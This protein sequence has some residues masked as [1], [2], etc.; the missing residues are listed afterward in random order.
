MYG[1]VDLSEEEYKQ[2]YLKYKQKYNDLKQYGGI[3]NPTGVVCF[4]TSMEKANEIT[5]LFSSSS[6]KPNF[7]TISEK[8]H[9]DG[10]HLLAGGNSLELMVKP[11][12]V[13]SFFSKQ[14]ES[15]T[16]V[17]KQSKVKLARTKIFNYCDSTHIQDVKNV[18]GTYGF[19]PE[20]MF[21]VLLNN[22]GADALITEKPVQIAEKPVQ[23][24]EKPVQVAENIVQNTEK[25]VQ[26]NE[27][28][29]QNTEKPVQN[30]EN[31][32]QNT[33][34][35]VQNAA[36]SEQNATRSEQNY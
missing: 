9:N 18:L 22:V 29:V 11:K 13:A 4:F 15:Q 33:E 36:R 30:A 21:V 17:L 26:N 1:V 12:K 27:K 5:A 2:K 3:G 14:T 25:P 20:A 7:N 16:E 19:V 28:L 23:V 31:I 24:A 8:L 34:K 32:V 6:T 35:P 10:Y